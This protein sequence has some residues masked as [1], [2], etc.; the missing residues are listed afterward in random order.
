M[1]P[2]PSFEQLEGRNLLSASSPHSFGAIGDSYTDEYQFYAPDRSTAM[3]YV[4]Q[5]ADDR[6]LDFGDFSAAPPRSAPRSQGFA[7]NWA[8]SADATTD[9]GP[10][11][12]T[13]GLAAQAAAGDVD[14]AF[15]FA[16]GNDFRR[17][18]ASSD[19]VAALGTVV[20]T[21]VT[22]V[23]TAVQ[24]LLASSPDV[25]VVVATVPPISVLPEVR[26]AIAAGFLPQALADA[27][28]FAIGAFN[29]QI[30]GLAASSD[31]VALADVDELVDDIFAGKEFKFDGVT[32]DRNSASNDPASLFLADGI[33]A[34]TVGQGLL[35][36]VFVDAMNGEF[37]T[38][39]RPL[40]EREILENAGYDRS[41][42][43]ATP[44]PVPPARPGSSH[45]PAGSRRACDEMF[46]AAAITL[47]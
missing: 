36:N 25:G 3:N 20:P 18:F 15:V 24:T 21:A 45:G 41:H 40:S 37:C 8:Q 35:A 16:G 47:A 6:H 2:Q 44:A 12:Q 32:I 17:V 46:G 34:G 39:I 4:E 11:G 28:D 10:N 43:H 14:V 31:R 42:G 38:R 13:A 23:F 30:R 27:V 9:L 29:D 5:L 22:N 33:H 7:N 26:G 19:P 1:R